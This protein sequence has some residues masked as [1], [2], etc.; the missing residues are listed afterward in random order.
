[1]LAGIYGCWCSGGAWRSVMGN[2]RGRKDRARRGWKVGSPLCLAAKSMCVCSWALSFFLS[3][4][5]ESNTD[6]MENGPTK[7][8]PPKI[9]RPS[10]RYLHLL[11]PVGLCRRPAAGGRSGEEPALAAGNIEQDFLAQGGH[12][13]PRAGA[14]AQHHSTLASCSASTIVDTIREFDSNSPSALKPLWNAQ[15][16]LLCRAFPPA[17]KD[18]LWAELELLVMGTS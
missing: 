8:W 9:W 7:S 17:G 11:N 10:L 4:F 16:P 2:G 18:N 6:P 1:M 15:C 3:P 5:N 14:A 12:S 13:V